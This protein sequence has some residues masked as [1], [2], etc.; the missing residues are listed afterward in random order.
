MQQATHTLASSSDVEYE[1]SGSKS[2]ADSMQQ[3]PDI[4]IATNGSSNAASDS[5]LATLP[6]SNAP[7]TS[8]H[9]PQASLP[10]PDLIFVK[11]FADHHPAP[12]YR[13]CEE[14]DTLLL[15]AFLLSMIHAAFVVVGLQGLT[16][17]PEGLP[18]EYLREILAL[19]NNSRATMNSTAAATLEPAL[20][21][22]EGLL[23]ERQNVTG[24]AHDVHVGVNDLN[25]FWLAGLA[26]SLAALLVGMMCRQWLG[27][28]VCAR[29]AHGSSNS[30]H[31][32]FPTSM[33]ASPISMNAS[34]TPMNK[35]PSIMYFWIALLLSSALRPCS[36]LEAWC[37]SCGS[38]FG[39]AFRMHCSSTFRQL[40]SIIFLAQTLS[41]P[42]FYLL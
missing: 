10:W 28:L 42:A 4:L 14:V 19:V 12:C 6:A 22:L 27:E 26:L 13:L 5:T 15:W 40:C 9:I 2:T 37:K 11:L 30:P 16:K 21:A 17:Q 18:T 38:S 23:V 33:N 25:V 29:S 32:A 34:P 35:F 7:A 39:P 41:L 1:A 20:I 8:E 3:A 36:S 24:L 31:S